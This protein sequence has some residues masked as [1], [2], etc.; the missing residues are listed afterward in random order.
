M[1]RINRQVPGGALE[2]IGILSEQPERVIATNTEQPA[3]LT[4]AVIVIHVQ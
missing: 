4:G 1:L 3:N 2:Q